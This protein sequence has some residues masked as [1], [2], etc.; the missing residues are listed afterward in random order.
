MR[1]FNIFR[2]DGAVTRSETVTKR[3]PAG[4]NTV[5]RVSV[6]EGLTVKEGP[7]NVG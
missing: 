7:K 3:A 2:T 4:R 1:R 6:G 5:K